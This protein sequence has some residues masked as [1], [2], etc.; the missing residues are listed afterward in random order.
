MIYPALILS[1]GNISTSLKK[2]GFWIALPFDSTNFTFIMIDI[3]FAL[4]NLIAGG[5]MYRPIPGK[6]W[7]VL[8]AYAHSQIFMSFCNFRIILET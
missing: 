5:V 3:Y 2:R 4:V 7:C 6:K 1:F 8:N